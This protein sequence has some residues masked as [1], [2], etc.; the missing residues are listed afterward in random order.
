MSKVKLRVVEIGSTDAYASKDAVTI[1]GAPKL[2]AGDVI[3]FDEMPKLETW[4]MPF[5]H[6]ANGF[7]HTVGLGTNGTNLRTG[8]REHWGFVAIKFEKVSE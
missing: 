5:K 3:Q 4:D 6:P 7:D 2:R 8:V 1:I